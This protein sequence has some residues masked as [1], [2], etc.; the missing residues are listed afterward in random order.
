[1]KREKERKRE[2]DKE[3]TREKERDTERE[4]E[5][6]GEIEREKKMRECVFVSFFNSDDVLLPGYHS[7]NHSNKD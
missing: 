4:K 5:S 6:E 3:R 7:T 1:M 2:R